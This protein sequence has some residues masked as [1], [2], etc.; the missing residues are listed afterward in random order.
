MQNKRGGE[1]MK[2]ENIWLILIIT[3]LV[4]FLFGGFGGMMGGGY[5]MMGNWGYGFGGMWLF[6]V[7]FMSLILIAL[8]LFIIWL[9]KQIEN[10]GKR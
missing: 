8:I 3:V 1:N 7:L 10:S 5:G 9:I 6:G 4:L 2:D